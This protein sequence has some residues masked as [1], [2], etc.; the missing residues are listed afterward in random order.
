SSY[1]TVRTT[2][3]ETEYIEIRVDDTV[4]VDVV[5]TSGDLRVGDDG[6]VSV[7][8]KNDGHETARDAQVVVVSNKMFSADV[9]SKYIGVLEPGQ[10]VTSEF[11]VSVNENAVTGEYPINVRLDYQGGNGV[12]HQ[13][14]VET[15]RV[16]VGD[17]LEFDVSAEPYALYVDS[18]GAVNVTVTNEGNSTVRNARVMM[19]E[20]PPFI[21]VSSKSSIGDLA[22]G[23]SETTQFRVEV[24]GRAVAQDYPLSFQVEYYNAFNETVTSDES[25]ASVKVGPERTFR[26]VGTPEV[27][28]GGTQTVTFTFESQGRFRDAVARINTDTPFSTDDDT[29]YLGDLEPGERVNATFKVTVDGSATPKE[30]SVD[31]EI[32]YENAFGEKVVS[33]LEKAPVKVTEGEGFLASMLAKILGIF[34]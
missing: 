17:E 18:I 9:D 31:A 13:S 4:D 14:E 11:R 8:V 3:T 21:P 1:R 20:S 27:S 5:D 34:G 12:A 22:P 26:V 19:K 29:A 6:R 2:E 7:T 10:R 30:Y 28:A 15:G 23:E 32:K 25:T 24:S 33:E 16:E